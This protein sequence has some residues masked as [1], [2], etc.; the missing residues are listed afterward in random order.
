MYEYICLP[1]KEGE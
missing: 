1:M